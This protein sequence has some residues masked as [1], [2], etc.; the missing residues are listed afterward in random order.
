[1]NLPEGGYKGEYDG[2]K[3]GW[4]EKEGDIKKIMDGKAEQWANGKIKG[5]SSKIQKCFSSIYF[6]FSHPH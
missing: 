6:I 1:M 3:K 5:K 2:R 4:K